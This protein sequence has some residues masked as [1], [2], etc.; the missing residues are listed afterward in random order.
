MTYSLSQY[1][2]LLKRKASETDAR[3]QRALRR[4]ADR[5]VVMA[6][7]RSLEVAHDTGAFAYGWQSEDRGDGAA[8]VNPRAHAP[9]VDDGRD[10]GDAPPPI[11]VLLRWVERRLH[12]G[13][14]E[15]E[16]AA[17][18]ISREIAERGIKGKEITAWLAKKL[19]PVAQSEV[20][21]EQ[22]KL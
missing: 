8:V 12:L 14:K 13:G 9:Y 22:E 18:A 1:A 15:A 17:Y 20:A 4:A 10:P 3:A 21:K 2:D 11:A 5:G 7:K 19:A 6:R 16:R